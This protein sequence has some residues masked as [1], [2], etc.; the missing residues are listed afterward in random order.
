MTPRKIYGDGNCLYRT[1]S[2]ACYGSQS[3][4]LHLR[5]LN[6]IELI[7]HRQYYDTAHEN[8]ID[9]IQDNN[10]L[11]TRY[12]ELINDTCKEGSYSELLHI[13]GL[14]SALGAPILSYYP[15]TATN[16]GL[17][18]SYSRKIFG[19]EVGHKKTE[20]AHIMWTQVSISEREFQFH[21][22]HF[23]PLWKT[24]P[25]VITVSDDQN[26][27]MLI[28]SESEPYIP[29][30][31]YMSEHLDH[32]NNSELHGNSQINVDSDHTNQS[33]YSDTLSIS[34]NVDKET[35]TEGSLSDIGELVKQQAHGHSDRF[36]GTEEILQVL[37]TAT[38]VL[39]N[40]RQKRKCLFCFL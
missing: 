25:D 11:I 39:E 18:K 12:H 16:S 27:S 23:V 10:V 3:Y 36:L 24:Q 35:E 15:P 28:E 37:Q 32:K 14:S 26:E 9:L 2:L 29:S 20:I 19:R 30:D 5:L 33:D 7:L 4:H 34:S 17:Y 31:D 40:V 1:I 38:N 21:P 13:Y 6:S 22:N 8:Y